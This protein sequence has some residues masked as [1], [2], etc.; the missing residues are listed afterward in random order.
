MTMLTPVCRIEDVPVGEGRVAVVD[1]HPVALFRI[2]DGFRALDTAC[3]TTRCGSLADGLLADS[4]V[5]CPLHLRRFDLTTGEALG[6]DSPA[7]AAHD[8][9]I[10]GNAVYIG[11]AHHDHAAVAA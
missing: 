8:V 9:E 7:V 11:L 3:P 1:G 5:T 10:R 6:Q 4:S 2:E